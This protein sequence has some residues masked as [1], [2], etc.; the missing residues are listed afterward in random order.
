VFQN[1]RTPIFSGAFLLIFVKFQEYFTKKSVFFAIFWSFVEKN[2]KD[3]YLPL[4]K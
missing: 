2:E 3:E 4:N 1:K